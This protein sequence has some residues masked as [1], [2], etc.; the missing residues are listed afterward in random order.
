MIYQ[1]NP[2]VNHTQDSDCVVDPST[3]C[4]VGCGVHHGEPCDDCGERA[5]HLRDCCAQVLERNTVTDE[6]GHYLSIIEA[7]DARIGELIGERDAL[8]TA[9]RRIVAQPAGHTTADTQKDLSAMWRIA[10]KALD[11]TR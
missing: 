7:R 6:R 8:V 3:G 11:G 1:A 9:L 5:F 2:I 10:N 4:C